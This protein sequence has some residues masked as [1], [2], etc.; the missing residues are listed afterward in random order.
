MDR[1]KALI[2]YENTVDKWAYYKGQTVGVAI[3]D[4]GVAPHPDLTYKVRGFKDFIN[5]YSY[6]YDDNGHGT[7]IAGIL[8]G[9]GK[10]SNGKY[11]GVAPEVDLYML[12]VLDKNGSGEVEHMIQAM[13]WVLENHLEFNIKVVNMSVGGGKSMDKNESYQ[14]L[15]KV[16]QLWE[17]GLNIV[18]SAG[19]N[20]PGR[21]TI[22]V[23]GVSKYAITV[24][25]GDDY[26]Y[27]GKKGSMKAN[28]SGRGPTKEGL[29]KPNILAPGTYIKSCNYKHAYNRNADA[30]ILKSGTSMATPVVSGAIASGLLI[31]PFLSNIDIIE[32]LEKSCTLEKR[33]T[34]EQG[35]GYLDMGKFLD[36]CR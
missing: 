4:T 11:M 26:M 25:A 2:N 34:K 19:N 8:C 28:Y 18:T 22:T 29:I 23:P 10:S 36:K 32:K 31:N 6:P 15:D 35:W 13:D 20:G 5:G 21:G 14:L 3:L 30:Y 1:V 9:S 33:R 7:H 24:G 12:K 17:A 16:E 27:K